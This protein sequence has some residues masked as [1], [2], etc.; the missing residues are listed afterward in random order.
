MA[1]IA[2]TPDVLPI[3]NTSTVLIA[4]NPVFL[5]GQ[6]IKETDTNRTKAGDG[7]STYTQLS[8]GE[9]GVEIVEAA[10]T[11]TYTGTFS[12]PLFLAYFPMMRI[13]VRFANAN[14][15]ASTINL[16]SL[17]AIAIR[18]SVSTA[19]SAGDILAGGIYDLTYDST[20]FQIVFSGSGG[21]GGVTSV[22]GTANR[23]TSTGG[24]TPVIDIA[25]T[26]VGQASITTLGTIATGVWNG[27]LMGLA[28]GGTGTSTTFTAG[29]VVFAGVGGVYSQ[30]NANFFYDDANNRLGIGTTAPGFPLHVRGTVNANF[31]TRVE[32]T[33]N[34]VSAD[35]RFILLNDAGLAGAMI[36]YGSGY[37]TS[38]LY[39]LPNETVFFGNGGSNTNFLHTTGGIKF[40]CNNST[41]IATLNTSGLGIGSASIV[42]SSGIPL[43][44]TVDGNLG[45]LIDVLNANAGGS[46]YVAFRGNNGTS[47]VY[48]GIRGTGYTTSGLIVANQSFIANVSSASMLYYNTSAV[49]HIFSV[50]GVGNTNELIRFASTSYNVKIGL[51]GTNVT[52]ATT[53]GTKHLDIFD[54][55][56]PVGTLANGI[57]LYSTAGELRVMDASGNATLLSPH[58]KK[59]NY[60]IY[61]SVDTV[62]GKRLK[63]DMELF[64]KWLN[65]KMGTKF[66]HEN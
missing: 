16:N 64:M 2:K 32:N 33:S 62:T 1:F 6:S 5:Y 39:D 13:R 15:G 60:W 65:K 23:I 31:Q 21:G 42:A 14:T 12:K 9:W 10:G 55:T 43:Q 8:Y 22:T 54:G 34:G 50:G 25:A 30:D 35:S 29:S 44:I 63:I 52:R 27:T 28:Y 51:A 36:L 47:Q 37:T 4:T 59:T 41:N 58:E 38:G 24:A 17:G 56:A 57:S 18:K 49:D 3:A 40:W 61:D 46:N 45:Q 7:V 48:I 11:D 20:N 19:L 26:Y 66:V 53:E